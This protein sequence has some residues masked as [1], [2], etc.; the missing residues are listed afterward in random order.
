VD[1][2][3]I[4]T[5]CNDPISGVIDVMVR[6]FESRIMSESE[7]FLHAHVSIWSQVSQSTRRKHVKT[8]LPLLAFF[9]NFH[10]SHFAA[11]FDLLS[12]MIY[13][14]LMLLM[15]PVIACSRTL[16][17]KLKMVLS[18]HAVFS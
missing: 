7:Q 10:E 13:L 5:C 8:F 4:P 16:L 14:C 1:V 11:K 15:L 2:F 12:C 17:R 9:H 3:S 6:R 18:W